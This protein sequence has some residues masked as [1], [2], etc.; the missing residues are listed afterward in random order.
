MRSHPAR[1]GALA[2]RLG[3]RTVLLFLAAALLPLA[4][5]AALT[6]SEVSQRLGAENERR[7]HDSAKNAGLAIAS[8]LGQLAS[9]LRNAARTV[10]EKGAA[11]APAGLLGADSEA[12][13]RERFAGLQLVRGRSASPLFGAVGAAP[14]PAPAQRAHLLQGRVLLRTVGEPPV[15]ELCMPLYPDDPG[16]TLLAG[17]LQESWLLDH[18]A[19][20]ASGDFAILDHTG[21]ILFHSFAGV[22]DAGPLLE[23]IAAAP[24]SGSF[25]W[26]VH[27]EVHLGTYWRVF[28]RPQFGTD[29]IVVGSRSRDAALAAVLGFERWLLMIASIA[30]LLVVVLGIGQMRRILQPIVSLREAVRRVAAGDFE[31]RVAIDR[32][33]ELGDLAR[34][35]DDMT[36]RIVEQMRH[37]EAIERQLL[38]S[39]DEAVAAAH[40]KAAFVTNVSHEFRTPMTAILAAAEILEQLGDHDE[41]QTRREFAGIAV[42]EARRLA[43]LVDSVLELSAGGPWMFELTEVEESIYDAMA[44]LPEEVTARV[45]LEIESA[46]PSVL[47]MRERLCQLWCHLLENAAKFS[48]AISPIDVRARSEG[49][50]VVVEVVDRGVGIAARDLER[51]FE[52]FAQVGRSQMTDKAGGTGLGLTVARNIAERH[53]GRI[54]VESTVGEGSLFRVVLPALQRDPA[55]AAVAAEAA[56]VAAE[57]RDQAQTWTQN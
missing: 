31:T 16:G 26:T 44:M 46:L 51:I 20:H 14:L 57:V 29:L 15:L 37:R 23:A 24:A 22:P 49:D 52:P 54:A 10:V 2:S 35:F 30:L 50:D 47:G 41:P 39:R 1:P 18:A 28:L 3:R 33:D 25:E 48:D 12:Y 4:G 38:L 56:A 45:R 27:G 11:Q 17:R 21:R 9:D 55:E 40:A 32:D 6:L 13:L 5:F 36:A 8:R 7:L 42:G 43:R 53:G 34:A 19:L